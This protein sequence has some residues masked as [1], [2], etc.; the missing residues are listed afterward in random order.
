MKRCLTAFAA[1]ALLAVPALAL[2]AAPAGEP[3]KFSIIAQQPGTSFFTYATSIVRLLDEGLPKDSKVD[4]MPRGGSVANPTML[5]ERKADMA[6][7]LG[8]TAAWA[9]QGNKSVYP[10]YG[11]HDNIR[12]ITGGMHMSHT[13]VL[14]RKDYVEK[15]GLKTFDA[16]VKAKETPRFAMKP[17]GSVVIPIVE[18]MLAEYGTDLAA[19]RAAGKLTQAQPA[20]I[21][22]MLRDGRVDVYIDNVPLNHA[23]VTE[24]TLTNDMVFIPLPEASIAALDKVGMSRQTVPAGSY[25][26]LDQNYVTSSTGMVIMAH[27][28]APEAAVYAMAK[29]LVERKADLAKENPALADWNPEAGARPENAVLPLH[30]GAAKYYKERGWIK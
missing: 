26:G 17:A 10:D 6:M 4:V 28:D 19:L 24:L 8:C 30:P 14:A 18:T 2:A 7:A 25:K 5:N 20:Q 9:M 21:S 29:T 1:L 27:K 22:E 15:T 23:G 13:F 3:V 11:K 16:L 12:G